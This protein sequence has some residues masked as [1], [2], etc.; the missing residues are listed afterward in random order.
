[1]GGEDLAGLR[2]QV[3][4]MGLSDHVSFLGER[5]D[6][7]DLLRSADLYLNTSLYEGQPVAMLEAFSAALPV[8]ATNVAGNCELVGHRENGLLASVNSPEDMA[9]AIKSLLMNSALY[10]SLSRGALTK[11]R[12]FSIEGCT[13]NHLALYQEI[14]ASRSISAQKG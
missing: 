4:N 8:I 12:C 7:A 13:Q 3:Q 11:S 2:S 1:G 6:I 14:T 9:G 5:T 10:Q